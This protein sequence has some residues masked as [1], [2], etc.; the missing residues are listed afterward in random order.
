MRGMVK[1]AD[2][3][4]TCDAPPIAQNSVA[5]DAPV[6]CFLGFELTGESRN[7]LQQAVDSVA[8]LLRDALPRPPRLVP[9]RN[10][11]ATLLFF[12]SLEAEERKQVWAEVQRG[13]EGG[14]W[15]DVNFDWTRFAVW[16]SP[17]RPGLV[18]LEGNPYSAARHWPLLNR[19]GDA[20]FNKADLRHV[21][22]F[23][24]HIT[25]MRFRGRQDSV[26]RQWA[27]LEPQ[28]PKIAAESIRISAISF[29]LSTVSAS[30]PVYPREYTLPLM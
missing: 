8:A 30:Q 25:L 3:S 16:P 10:W 29:F 5:L 12:P 11:H 2:T 26:S 21:G 23:V 6:R 18:C 24:P 17:R 9:A 27:Q 19:I 1:R 15:Q 28:L 7:I 4:G 22:S 13:V 20:P 14:A